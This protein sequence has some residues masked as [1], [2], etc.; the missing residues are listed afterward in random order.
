MALYRDEDAAELRERRRKAQKGKEKA[1][2]E[3][4]AFLDPYTKYAFIA[5]KPM[6]IHLPQAKSHARAWLAWFSRPPINKLGQM[7]AALYIDDYEEIQSG[8]GAVPDVMV[9]MDS[10]SWEIL[11]GESEASGR[12]LNDAEGAKSDG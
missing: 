2:G 9:D 4:S 8:F 1:M 3:Q 7:T 10:G 12:S 11:L 6:P 5:D